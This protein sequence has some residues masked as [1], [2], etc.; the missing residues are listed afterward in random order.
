MAG[1]LNLIPRYLPHFGMAPEWALA[2][3]PLVLVFM[4]VATLVTVLFHAN[5]DAQGAPMR[6]ACWF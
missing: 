5:V 6:P 4:A 3:R 2:S 1:L